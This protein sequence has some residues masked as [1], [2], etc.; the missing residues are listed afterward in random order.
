VCS[1]AR[2]GVVLFAS[3]FFFCCMGGCGR[4][5]FTF[6]L[7]LLFWIRGIHTIDYDD[8]DYDDDYH[9]EKDQGDDTTNL[10]FELEHL[11]CSFAK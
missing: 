5:C 2:F 8:D 4:F 7:L 10:L 11:L 6:A 9:D 3:F 1:G